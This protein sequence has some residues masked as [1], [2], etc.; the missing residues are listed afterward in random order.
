MLLF[1]IHPTCHIITTPVA[2]HP[3]HQCYTIHHTWATLHCVAPGT[4]P[5]LHNALH[6]CCTMDRNFAASMFHNT[7]TSVLQQAPR[8]C[9]I[10]YMSD[11]TIHLTGAAPCTTP[12]T[13]G[14]QWCCQKL[15]ITNTTKEAAAA[16]VA[17]LQ[18]LLHAATAILSAILNFPKRLV[19]ILT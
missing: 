7:T 14:S 19:A 6:S 16:A 9:C 12:C 2:H 5:L 15:H 13:N 8:P 17:R 4:A 18:L 10:L 3:K 1:T 11:C